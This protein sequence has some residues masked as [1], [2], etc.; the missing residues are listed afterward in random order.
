LTGNYI[1]QKLNDILG[2]SDEPRWVYTDTD[3][4]YFE[5][6]DLKN[7]L[8]KK[9]FDKDYSD[10]SYEQRQ[11]IL[12]KTLNFTDEYIN[13]WVDEIIAY[14]MD[15]SHSY[16]NIILGAKLEKIADKGLFVAKKKYSLRVIYD[17]G[18]ILLEHPKVKTSGL[19]IVRSSTPSFC[20]SKLY[21][22]MYNIF[23]YDELYLQDYFKT[24]R[25]EFVKQPIEKISKVSG[26]SN[27][28]YKLDAKGFYRINPET[29]KRV[30]CPINSRAALVHNIIVQKLNLTDFQLITAG[31]KIK[32]CH[33]LLPNPYMSNIV[34]YMDERFIEEANLAEFIDYDTCFE[35]NFIKPLEIMLDAIGWSAVKQTNIDEWI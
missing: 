33:L 21:E 8:C 6:K 1:E 35:K 18:N 24:V 7:M 27:L 20:K 32:Y 11:I 10:I 30:P 13:K 26:V 4:C 17:E 9:L 34:G 15:F 19:E 23:E 16:D 28:N 14:Y 31:E 25:D 12:E 5:L 29:N 22:G 2:K 3:S